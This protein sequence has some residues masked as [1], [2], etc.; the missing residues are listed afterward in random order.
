MQS[1]HQ[2]TAQ[3]FLAFIEQCHST[4]SDGTTQIDHVLVSRYGI[5][6]IETKHYSGWI[7]GDQK[8]KRWTQVIYNQK[9]RFQNPLH[10]NY[11]HLKAVQAVLDF[12]SPGQI[13]SVVVFTG[14]AEF[15][16]ERPEGVYSLEDLVAHLKGL[17]QMH[18]SENRMQFLCWPP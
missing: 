12:V 18:L 13:S 17:Q 10:Q 4:G 1:S 3:R 15:M 16:S 5:F 8:S 7:F 9:S 14:N 2:A 6:V 11:K